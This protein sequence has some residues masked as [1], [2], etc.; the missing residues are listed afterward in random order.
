MICLQAYRRNTTTIELTEFDMGPF[1][2]AVPV[3]D[4][5]TNMH[6]CISGL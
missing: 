3:E 1:V 5:L 4:A 6:I 2:V